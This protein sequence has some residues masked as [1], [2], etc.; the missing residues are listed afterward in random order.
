MCAKVFD[1]NINSIF[2]ILE[3][4]KHPE[5]CGASRL[6]SCSPEFTR[7]SGLTTH[8]KDFII[9]FI[10]NMNYNALLVLKNSQNI[11]HCAA[12][13]ICDKD[14]LNAIINKLGRTPPV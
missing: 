12:Y 13:C 7:L 14:I 4:D 6:F 1:E 8:N 11:L 5:P 10:N 3:A 2:S 9:N